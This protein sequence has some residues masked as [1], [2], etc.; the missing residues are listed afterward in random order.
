MLSKFV[1][2]VR[3]NN[4]VRYRLKLRDLEKYDETVVFQ[5]LTGVSRKC[6]QLVGYFLVKLRSKDA[7][8]RKIPGRFIITAVSIF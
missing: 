5:A 2:Q 7:F 1:K 3:M 8:F 4:R 6:D